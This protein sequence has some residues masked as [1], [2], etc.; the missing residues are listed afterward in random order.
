MVQLASVVI[1]IIVL[2]SSANSK[3]ANIV[4]I[5][6]DDLGYG[7]VGAYGAT[8]V[9]TPNMD[10]LAREGLLF[11]DGHAPSATCTPSRYAMLTGE[12]AWRQQGTGIARGDAGAIIQPGRTTLA[13]ILRDAGY[14]TGVVGKWHL[15]LGPGP[16]KT[17]WNSEIKPGPLEIGFDYC[18]L[19][20]ATG[21]RVPCVFV[22]NHRVVDLDANDPIRVSFDGPVGDEP[23]GKA[24]PELLRMHPSHGHDQTIINGIS[25]IGYM[26]GGKSARWV[27]QDIADRFVDQAVGFIDRNAG[28]PFFLYFS[29]HDIHV[30]RAP[31]RRFVG[32]TDMGP[33]GD[34][35]AEFDWCV[36]EILS[37]LDRLKLVDDTLVILTSDNGPVVDDGYRDDAVT[38]LGDHKP[39]GPFRGGKYSNFEGGTRVPWIV[40]WPQQ[41]KPGVSDALICQVDLPASLAKLTNQS[42]AEGAAPDSYDISAALLGDSETGRDHLV[43]HA[44]RTSLRVGKWKYIPP[45]NAAK[46]NKQTNTELGNDPQP[47][48]YD[49][50]K[51]PGETDNLATQFPDRIKQMSEQLE[52]IKAAGFSVK[53]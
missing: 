46:I 26:E 6:A 16:G 23:T 1:G 11:T 44:G 28:N 9:K 48:L 17:D 50:S 22:E 52:Q 30:P 39:A 2:S 36:G 29:L 35:I 10:R 4:I 8:A 19:M 40:R 25:R 41:I 18:Y 12:Y 27:D 24:H 20:P 3:P 53:R 42:L 5:Y 37:A 49:L 21:D 15:G 38:R 43:E 7:D 47:Q 32:A 34:A 31:H 13:S 51:D 33:R 14:R 45:S